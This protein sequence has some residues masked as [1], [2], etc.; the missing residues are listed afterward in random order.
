[1]TPPP[2]T[3]LL[4]EDDA[5]VRQF[6]AMALEEEPLRLHACASLAA[7]RAWA[8][9]AEQAP[10]AV[11]LDL[12][13]PDGS[14]TQL[15][16]DVALRARWPATAWVLFSAG[17]AAQWL[18]DAALAQRRG[19]VAV[20]E[21]PVSLSRLLQ[22]VRAACAPLATPV[23]AEPVAA[24]RDAVNPAATTAVDADGSEA[25]QADAVARYFEGQAAL[26][27][28]MRAF[29][30]PQLRRELAELSAL[31]R[32][33]A[34]SPVPPADDWASARRLAHSMKTVLAMLAC[35]Q[36]SEQA[37]QAELCAESRHLAGLMNACAALD[38]ATDRCTRAAS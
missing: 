21:K 23:E 7:A 8:D 33:L 35:P 19:V 37:R 9:A 16:E 38:K 30:A 5:A 6:V 13:L 1:M 26:F 4:V 28:Q 22:V 2:K 3:L 14:G 32:A 11:L 10:D 17:R 18:N 27:E 15:L 20:L 31:A 29:S 12:M 34:A 25:A 24:L 36:A